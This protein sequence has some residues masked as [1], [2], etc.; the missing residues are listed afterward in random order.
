V[1]FNF[2]TLGIILPYAFA[3]SLVG[4]LESFLTANVIDDMTDTSRNKHQEAI[5]QGVA[6]LITG[7]F[8]GMAD[9][10]MI[11]QSIINIRSGGRTRLSTLSAGI[12]LLI[13]I[14]ALGD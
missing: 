11:G 9:C 6:N 3:R 2:E 7:F 1:P 13:F 4:L 8:G 12:F 5:R 14:L 10:A